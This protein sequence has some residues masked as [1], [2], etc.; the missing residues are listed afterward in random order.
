MAHTV[1][2]N[3]YLRFLHFL[4]Q[5]R[6]ADDPRSVAD[7]ATRLVEAGDDPDDRA[8]SHVS[9]VCDLLEGLSS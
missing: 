5:L 2:L 1:S 6:V 4:E 7:L 9:E 8:L 3:L